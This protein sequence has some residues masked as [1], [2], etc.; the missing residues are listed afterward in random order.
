MKLKFRIEGQGSCP[1]HATVW[2]NGKIVLDED[3][4]RMRE[5]LRHMACATGVYD[6]TCIAFCEGGLYEWECEATEEDIIEVGSGVYRK[7]TAEE[8]AS[9]FEYDKMTGY[10]WEHIDF[11]LYYQTYRHWEIAKDALQMMKE[12]VYDC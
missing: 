11:R 2:K 6:I 10:E 1:K 12:D 5:M 9:S 8:I 3:F 7:P 4:G